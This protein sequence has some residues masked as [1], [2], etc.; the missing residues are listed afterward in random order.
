MKTRKNL[1]IICEGESTEPGY[2]DE[3]RDEIIEKNIDYSIT[4]LPKP[5]VQIKAEQSAQEA[6]TRN[7]G[8]RRAVRNGPVNDAYMVEDAYAAQPTRYVREAQ[9]GLIDG[10]YDEAWAVYD[11]DGHPEHKQAYE[12]AQ[13]IINNRKVHVGFSS[14]SFEAWVLWHFEQSNYPFQKT[15]CRTGKDL[16]DCG[17]TTHAKDCHGSICVTG[18][19]KTQG[20]IGVQQDVKSVKYKELKDF[21][22]TALF[23]AY[24]VRMSWHGGNG[25][26]PFYE[27]NP[28]TTIDRLVFKLQNLPVDYHWIESADDFSVPDLAV[29]VKIAHPTIEIKLRNTR[30]TTQIIHPDVVVLVNVKGEQKPVISRSILAPSEIIDFTINL[31][32]YLE[33]NPIY[34]AVKIWEESYQIVEL[35]IP[36]RLPVTA[37]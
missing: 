4:I 3:L 8:R 10:T 27:F 37:I 18:H 11:L 32:N 29:E 15:Q 14:I 20:Y 13:E 23:N 5:P 24:F 21:V 6:N 9:L 19:L 28:Y 16:H 31:N 22:Y 30:N 34:I 25:K 2:F 36:P 35:P 26:L 17:Q 7:G 33:H 1:L 12:L